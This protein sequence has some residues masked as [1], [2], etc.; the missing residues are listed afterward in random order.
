MFIA[1]Q[2]C[3]GETLVI[4]HP[5]VLHHL[6]HVLRVNI[7][8]QVACCDGRGQ[9]A[10]G[11]IRRCAK[12]QIEVAVDR[13]V[14]ESVPSIHVQLAPALIKPERFE[15]MLEKATELGVSRILPLLTARTTVRP[16]SSQSQ[17]RMTRWR[18]IIEG[19]AMQC[20]RATLPV[21]EEPQPLARVLPQLRDGLL[22]IPTLNTTGVSLDELVPRP[23]G[24]QRC[25]M[26]IGPEGDFTSEEVQL[27]ITQGAQPVRL[28][29]RILRSE[30]AAIVT[31][32][33]FQHCWGAL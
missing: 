28:G 9:T 16:S 25:A 22:V 18:R 4:E 31:L 26:L 2:G 10:M 1:P 19:A 32:A 27:A 14:K 23:H 17:I 15:W 3:Q 13:W 12:T 30:T 29:R 20:G 5:L 33:L 11:T 24:I 8:D 7:G 6:L 21:L